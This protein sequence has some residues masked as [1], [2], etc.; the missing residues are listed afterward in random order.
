[1][2]FLGGK[3]SIDSLSH[4]LAILRAAQGGLILAPLLFPFCPRVLFACFLRLLGYDPRNGRP[5]HVNLDLSGNLQLHRS[6]IP[7][8]HD[9]TVNTAAG[10][11]AISR[12]QVAEQCLK[13]FTLLRLRPKNQEIPDGKKGGEKEK[14]LRKRTR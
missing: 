11:H 1:M 10:H 5:C 9:R 3:G 13:L 4:S 7:E 12:L 6:A 8:A 2:E 14:Q